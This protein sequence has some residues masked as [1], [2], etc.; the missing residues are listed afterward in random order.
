[1]SDKY[2]YDLNS[3]INTFQEHCREY[4]EWCTRSGCPEDFHLALA[5]REICLEIRDMKERLERVSRGGV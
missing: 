3:L 1:M 2:S 4:E 5:L